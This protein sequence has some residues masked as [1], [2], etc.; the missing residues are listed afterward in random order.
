VNTLE[1]P[2]E[3]RG[4][5]LL[6]GRRA[7]LPHRD[8][9]VKVG[10]APAP[11]PQRKRGKKQEKCA[12]EQETRAPIPLRLRRK[13]RGLTFGWDSNFHGLVFS[14]EKLDRNGSSF[15]VGRRSTLPSDCPWQ[16]NTATHRRGRNL[17]S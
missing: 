1:G 8:G 14:G 16:H 4:Y 9:V 11:P 15:L 10:D 13:A 7:I 5:I 17:K 12:A 6:Y 2:D 3:Y